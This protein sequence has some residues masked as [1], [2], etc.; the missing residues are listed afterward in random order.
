MIDW[1]DL[2][3]V[4]GTLQS[5]PNHSQRISSSVLSLLYGPTLIPSMTT[6]KMIALSIRTFVSEVMSLLFNILSRL[7][8]TFL[9]RSKRLFGGCSHHLQ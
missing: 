1:L 9:P 7:V 5:S 4:Q 6:G 3:A 8:I 2:F